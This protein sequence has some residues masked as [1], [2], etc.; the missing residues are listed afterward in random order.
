MDEPEAADIARAVAEHFQ[1]L[2]TDPKTETVQLTRKEATMTLGLLSGLVEILDD[3]AR[4][5]SS[6]VSG[7]LDPS[8]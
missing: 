7:H 6:P 5:R 3:D 4:L 1:T 8:G 2:L